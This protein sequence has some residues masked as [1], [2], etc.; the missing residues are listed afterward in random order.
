MILCGYGAHLLAELLPNTLGI[1]KVLGA[2]YVLYLACKVAKSKPQGLESENENLGF[3]N[4]FFLQFVNVKIIL[5]GITIHLSFV[6]PY[7]H[8]L[9]YTSAFIAYSILIGFLGILL[10]IVAGIALKAFLVKHYKIANLTMA[11]LL[12]LS[13]VQILV[14]QDKKMNP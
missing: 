13:A 12:V 8:S 14:R 10:W 1:L 11:A 3:F 6:L 4:A 2:G 7:Y 5:Y 9:F